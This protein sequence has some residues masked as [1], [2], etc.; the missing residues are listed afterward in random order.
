M[1]A[2]VEQLTMLRGG[3][4]AIEEGLPALADGLTY[5]ERQTAADLI[6]AI[7][8]SLEEVCMECGLHGVTWAA[9]GD[10]DSGLCG[11]VLPMVDRDLRAEWIGGA[12]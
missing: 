6:I 3:V 1:N 5:D 11:E 7:T 10:D 12:P 4:R 8:G 9:L 2:L